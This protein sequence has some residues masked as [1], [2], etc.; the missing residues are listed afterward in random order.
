MYEKVFQCAAGRGSCDVG[1][2]MWDLQ[3]GILGLV[4]QG[5]SCSMRVP[6][7]GPFLGIEAR[8]LQYSHGV[9]VA[10]WKDAGVAVMMWEV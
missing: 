8:E 9:R 5:R 4:C 6:A 7:K 3:C 10:V 2:R 1:D